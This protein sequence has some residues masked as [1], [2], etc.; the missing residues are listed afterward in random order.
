MRCGEEVGGKALPPKLWSETRFA[1]HAGEVFTVFRRNLELLCSLLEKKLAE[2]TRPT[3]LAELRKELAILKDEGVRVRLRALEDMYRV[4]GSASKTVQGTQALPWERQAG[5]ELVVVETINNMR[6]TLI[7]LYK[8]TPRHIRVAKI[9]VFCEKLSD[10][11]TYR[12]KGLDKS[13]SDKGT[14][15]TTVEKSMLHIRQVAD[16]HQ[17]AASDVPVAVPARL[18]RS[19]AN[20]LAEGHARRHEPQLERLGDINNM[21]EQVNEFGDVLCDCKKGCLRVLAG[22]AATLRSLCWR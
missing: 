13:G 14:A 1:P 21:V 9:V 16:L 17:L 11:L 8:K 19:A 12:A 20:R 2:E 10:R 7:A 18:V 6:T 4:L 3:Q 5:Q 22:G 15:N